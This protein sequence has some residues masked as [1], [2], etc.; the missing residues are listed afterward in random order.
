MRKQIV[1]FVANKVILVLNV[2]NILFLK[3]FGIANTHIVRKFPV[4]IT[5]FFQVFEVTEEQHADA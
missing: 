5:R 4:R 1:I 3:M 2:R